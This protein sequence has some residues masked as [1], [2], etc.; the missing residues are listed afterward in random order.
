VLFDKDTAPECREQIRAWK[1]GLPQFLPVRYVLDKDVFLRSLCWPGEQMLT[2]RLDN[3]DLIHPEYLRLI[4]QR[5]E[6]VAGDDPVIISAPYGRPHGK[7]GP[8]DFKQ[9]GRQ[10]IYNMFLSVVAPMSDP[11]I[12]CWARPHPDM[13]LTGW[14]TELI[15]TEEPMWT[16]VSHPLQQTK[17]RSQEVLKGSDLHEVDVGTQPCTQTQCD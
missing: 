15:E 10:H 3:D 2:T 1:R 6:Q 11:P 7:K 5:A 13:R 4:R 9:Y 17:L 16:W 12:H 8:L 14:H